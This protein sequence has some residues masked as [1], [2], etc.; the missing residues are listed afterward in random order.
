[1]ALEPTKWADISYVSG[2]HR[3]DDLKQDVDYVNDIWENNDNAIN[4]NM[5][6]KIIRCLPINVRTQKL[7]HNN[8][9][10]LWKEMKAKCQN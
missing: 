9:K 5:E 3:D 1:M 6:D 8:K 10:K 2:E 4:N 7:N